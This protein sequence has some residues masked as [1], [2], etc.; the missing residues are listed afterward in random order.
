MPSISLSMELRKLDTQPKAGA[1]IPGVC[2]RRQAAA[3]PR[4]PAL[5]AALRYRSSAGQMTDCMGLRSS[6]DGLVPQEWMETV[7][8]RAGLAALG[9]RATVR[10]ILHSLQ[11]RKAG[12]NT[13][14]AEP[15]VGFLRLAF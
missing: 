5:H 8:T 9:R 6:L 4:A 11:R 2:E 1:T 10:F 15:L 3:A 7:C 12:A 14:T 13:M